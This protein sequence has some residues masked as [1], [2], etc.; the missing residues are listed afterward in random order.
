MSAVVS[1]RG[2]QARSRPGRVGAAQCAQLAVER[3]D[4]VLL[5]PRL[6]VGRV[7]SKDL[8]APVSRARYSRPMRALTFVERRCA[9]AAGAWTS[10]RIT[11]VRPTHAPASTHEVLWNAELGALAAS[12]SH[13][14]TRRSQGP[15]GTATAD[16]ARVRIKDG[17]QRVQV[18]PV[19]VLEATVPVVAVLPGLVKMALVA[20]LPVPVKLPLVTVAV[21]TPCANDQAP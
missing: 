20:I 9:P 18:L 4:E 2:C 19:V 17:V 21:V 11:S 14:S 6:A 13:W 16:G 7:L 8:R 5:R 12:M 3:V 15:T 1:W 10:A